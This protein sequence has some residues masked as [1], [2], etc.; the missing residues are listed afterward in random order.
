MNGFQSFTLKSPGGRLLVLKTECGVSVAFNPDTTIVHPKPEKYIA[1]W[2][3][4]ATGTVITKKVVDNLGLKPIAKAISY[5]ANG[6]S[7][8][9]VYAINLILPNT[10]GFSTLT[11]TEGI[12]RNADV[13]IGMDVITKGDFSITNVNNNTVFTFRYPSIK[14][15]DYTK[16]GKELEL[17]KYKHLRPNDICPCGSHKKFKHC[18][19]A[20]VR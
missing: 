17:A 10:V 20:A 1:I 12:L 9:N 4:G 19:G 15:I 7:E 11:V 16:E 8:V 18:H 2:D 5:H 3:T 13:L 6:S 14:E